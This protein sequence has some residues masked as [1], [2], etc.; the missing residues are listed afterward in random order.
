MIVNKDIFLVIF[1]ISKEELDN[2]SPDTPLDEE[3]GWDSMA[4]V[5]L[6][7]EISETMDKVL[8]ADDL[9]SLETAGDLD[10]LISSQ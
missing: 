10:R 9:E 4:K 5:I 8:E 6:I 7:S 3:L 1:D 2:L